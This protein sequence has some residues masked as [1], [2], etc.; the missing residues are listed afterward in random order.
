MKLFY[1]GTYLLRLGMLSMLCFPWQLQ[2]QHLNVLRLA[3]ARI[4]QEDVSRNVPLKHVLTKIADTYQISLNYS[5][6]EIVPHDVAPEL[7]HA[8]YQNLDEA[9]QTVLRGSGL[10]YK[11]IGTVRLRHPSRPAPPTREAGKVRRRVDRSEK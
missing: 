4:T 5:E 7:V 3:D 9:L 1:Q 8:T 2:A 10:E 6:R 11:K